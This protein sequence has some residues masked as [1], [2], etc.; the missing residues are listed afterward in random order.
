[1]CGTRRL[2][3]VHELLRRQ[4][5]AG[6]ARAGRLD[7]E[8]AVLLHGEGL[9][10]LAGRVRLHEAQE[11]VRLGA[12]GLEVDLQLLVRIPLGAA[13]D[14]AGDRDGGTL[15]YLGRGLD[16]DPDLGLLRG[17]ARRGDDG[18]GADA[19]ERLAA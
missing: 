13:I 12:L 1:M 8:V 10:V 9:G 16:R 7:A 15:P 3:D 17:A 11:L 2:P 19:L 5:A 14:L 6:P 18:E 4:R